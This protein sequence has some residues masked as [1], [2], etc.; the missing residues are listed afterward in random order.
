MLRSNQKALKVLIDNHYQYV[1]CHNS[2]KICTTNEKR[3]AIIGDEH[4]LNYFQ[5]K[6][7]NNEFIIEK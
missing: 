7:A 6:F 1:F 2:G 3:N 4:S 5:E